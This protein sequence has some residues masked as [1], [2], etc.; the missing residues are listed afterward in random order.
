MLPRFGLAARVA[1]ALAGLT[2]T[3][4]V[5]AYTGANSAPASKAG[6]G[7]GSIAGYTISSVTYNLDATSPQNIDSVT[8]ALSTTPTTGSTIKIGLAGSSGGTTW[9]SCTN[10]GATLTC[11]TTSPQAT[12]WGATQ[13]GTASGCPCTTT[14]SGRLTDVVTH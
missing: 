7:S 12:A 1:L 3:G 14:A 13:G 5:Y 6:V 2:L 4:A 11:P 8:V 9:Y 10:A